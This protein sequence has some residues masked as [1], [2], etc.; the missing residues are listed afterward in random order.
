MNNTKAIYM[1]YLYKRHYIGLL[2]IKNLGSVPTFV[3]DF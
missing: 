2:K 1:L 3:H